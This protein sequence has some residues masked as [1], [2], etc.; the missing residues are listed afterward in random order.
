MCGAEGV[1][2]VS[3]PS[4]FAHEMKIILKNHPFLKTEKIKNK[5]GKRKY[6]YMLAYICIKY[7]WQ[8]I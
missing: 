8:D 5:R 2:E 4:S 3:V 6:L 1:W 7:L